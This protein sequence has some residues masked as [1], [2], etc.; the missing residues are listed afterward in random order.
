[1]AKR[2][3]QKEPVIDPSLIEKRNTEYGDVDLVKLYAEKG[4]VKRKAREGMWRDVDTANNTKYGTMDR[5]MAGLYNEAVSTAA[6]EYFQAMH[7][8]ENA[9]SAKSPEK[10]T[11]EA[12]EKDLRTIRMHYVLI[13]IESIDMGFGA[14]YNKILGKLNDIAKDEEMNFTEEL[15]NSVLEV[16]QKR[17]VTYEKYPKFYK[18]A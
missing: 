3:K 9:K 12:C 1:M 15:L 7:R 17:G 2:K 4:E 18:L 14:P 8:L 5:M 10:E 13:T 11:I 16:T 6:G